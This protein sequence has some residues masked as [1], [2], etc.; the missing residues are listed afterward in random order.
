MPATIL[1]QRLLLFRTQAVLHFVAQPDEELYVL[2]YR[3]RRLG[4][5]VL[6][7]PLAVRALLLTVHA[8][9]T[10]ALLAIVV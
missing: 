5:I 8:N 3:V 10:A 6:H 9:E 2:P 1:E 4:E 7:H